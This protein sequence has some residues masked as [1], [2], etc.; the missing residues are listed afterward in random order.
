MWEFGSGLVSREFWLRVKR[1]AVVR[2]RKD[3]N[4]GEE[5]V[6]KRGTF[7]KYGEKTEKKEKGKMK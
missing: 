5:T 7:G 3:T 2:G 6:S 4:R 1:P